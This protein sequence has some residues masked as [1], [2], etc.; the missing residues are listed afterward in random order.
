MMLVP[1]DAER[2]QRCLEGDGLAV[3]PT[4]TV[5]GLACNP[6]S[7]SAVARV[8]KLKGREPGKPAAVMFFSI[9]AAL[10]AF[11]E[12][13]LRTRRALDALLPGAV[14][15]LVPNPR[16][17]FPLACASSASRAASPPPVG[18]RVPRFEGPLT[19]LARVSAPAVQS[20]ANISGGPDP[21]RLCDVPASL[22]EGADLLL[23]GGE[24]PGT[25]STVVDLRAYETS[26]A[27]SVVRLG[28]V[29]EERLAAAL[30]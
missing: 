1:Q 12:L 22:R 8:Y 25:P 14:T 18:V 21:R 30:G 24:L 3:L 7:P 26:G 9:E 6:S 20:S 17:R 29:G 19:V 13:G 4:D 5:Y 15:L 27:W 10:A 11:P 2:V 23:D 28:A 16:G